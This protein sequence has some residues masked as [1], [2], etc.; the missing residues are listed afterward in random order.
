MRPGAR[1]RTR[2]ACPSSRPGI[3]RLGLLP[4]AATR[5]GVVSA[6]LELGGLG[7]QTPQMLDVGVAAVAGAMRHLGMLAGEP[8]RAGSDVRRHVLAAGA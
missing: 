8:R 3:G 1:W 6:E 5:A 4:A 2:S 7:A